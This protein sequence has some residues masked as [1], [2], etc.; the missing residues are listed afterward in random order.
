MKI[1]FTSPYSLLPMN[2]G[3]AVRTLNIGKAMAR[4]GHEVHVLGA[5]P[6]N[7]DHVLQHIQVHEFAAAGRFGHFS[8]R[9]FRHILEQLLADE[10]DLV[11]VGF[12]F[13]AWMVLPLARRYQVPVIYDAHNVEADR[14]KRMRRPLVAWAVRLA[15]RRLCNEAAGVF[16]VSEEDGALLKL[17]HGSDSMVLANGVDTQAMAPGRPEVKVLERY[18]LTTGDY[19]LFFGAYD[20]SPNQEA[21]RFLLNDVWPAVRRVLPEPKLALV[22]RCPKSWMRGENVVV[23][24]A[25]DDLV[26]LIRG[27]RV[28]L[29]P[30]FSGGG[31]R[32]KIVEALSCGKTLLATPFGSRGIFDRDSEA[33]HLASA[34]QFAVRLIELLQQVAADPCGNKAAR[35]L[36]KSYDWQLQVESV[37]P[38][39]LEIVANGNH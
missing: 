17:V 8:N 5:G 27:A 6:V 11:V 12:P 18:G 10:M 20:Y 39:L 38:R 9:D 31:T 29:A 1:L 13:Q 30:L 36:A 14:F 26:S 37:M 22:G 32:L 4:L 25:V 23:T 28:V 21:A 7:T 19:A 33:L 24:G 15:E 2:S 35:Q 34:E 3:G 16:T